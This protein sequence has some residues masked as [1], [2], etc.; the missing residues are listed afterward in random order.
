MRTSTG[1]SHDP[2]SNGGDEQVDATAPVMGRGEVAAA[3]GHPVPAGSRITIIHRHAD[4]DALAEAWDD[5]WSRTP[6]ATAFQVH[7]WTSAWAR[8]Y[9]PDGRLVVATV[10]NGEQLVA[11]APLHRVRRGAVQVLA[12][13]GGDLVDHTDVLLDPGV[14][15]A[16][17]RLTAALLA[18][19]GWRAVDL[20]E[21]LPAATAHSWAQTWPGAVRRSPASL[22]L[23][24][25][26][27]P[28]TEVL[29]RLPART[30][31]TLRRKIRKV[32]QLGVQRAELTPA[33]VTG[34]IPRLIQ[35]HEAQWA[36]R[37]GNP[38][39]LTERFRDFL[40]EAL[41]AMVARAQAVVVEYRVDGELVAAEVDLVGHR[42]LAYYLAGISPALRERIDTAVL[43]V[44][45]A[46]ERALRLGLDEYSFLRGDE[47][48]KFRW[49][50][51]EVVATRLLLARPGLL[52]SGGYLAFTAITARALGLARR[53]LRGRARE[54]ARAVMHGVRVVRARG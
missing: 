53:V 30:A 49:R 16:G 8:A 24:L 29:G 42:Q 14:P 35:L 38:E 6:A 40:C 21:A 41:P 54:L 17:A 1:V 5:L 46:L 43:L 23:Q 11:A 39:H 45:S 4:L 7:A 25:P 28:A 51:D 36:G 10:W 12:P 9:V 52:R 33:E 13:L 18:E 26:V 27:A 22:N 3:S 19:P 50:P 48:Y 47:D 2:A 34:A 20:S 15:D 44:S 37:R 31:S 32:D